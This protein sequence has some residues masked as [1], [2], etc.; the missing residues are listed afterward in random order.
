MSQI[1]LSAFG[2]LCIALPLAV[3]AGTAVAQEEQAIE[4][5]QDVVTMPPERM[6]VGRV[7][8]RDGIVELNGEEYRVDPEALNKE[9]RADAPGLPIGL[10]DLQPGMY[11]WVVTNGLEP[12]LG[13]R[14]TITA[15]W[16]S[17]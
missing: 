2:L 6:Q 17:E 7:R 8:D 16:R 13:E 11:V 5:L 10:D 12:G 3:G 14:P 1:R 4:S 15:L 9:Q